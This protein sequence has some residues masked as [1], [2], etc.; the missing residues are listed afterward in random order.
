MATLRPCVASSWVHPA[1]THQTIHTTFL[2]PHPQVMD[3]GHPQFTEAKILSE[4]I[5]TD[6]YKMAVRCAR[7]GWAGVAAGWQYC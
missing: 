1:S 6:A 4:Y 2:S 5:K 3:F 7:P